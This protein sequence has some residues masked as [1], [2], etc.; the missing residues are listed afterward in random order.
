MSGN[1]RSIRHCCKGYVGAWSVLQKG[2]PRH[3]TETQKNSVH[4]GNVN[5]WVPLA[6]EMR[7]QTVRALCVG[8]PSVIVLNAATGCLE[9]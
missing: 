7:F 3:G 5:R 6:G 1:N 2:E 9:A 8:P 4:L